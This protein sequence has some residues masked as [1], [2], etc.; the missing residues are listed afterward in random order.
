MSTITKRHGTI[1]RPNENP[2]KCACAHHDDG[3]T[4]TMLCPT[5]A[6]E[7]PCATMAAVTGKRRRGSIR[8]GVCT[9]CGWARS[10]SAAGRRA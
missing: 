6:K 3:S 5:H 2:A 1:N 9:S 8:K 10:M 7:D 4:T